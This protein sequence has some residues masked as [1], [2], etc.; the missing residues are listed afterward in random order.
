MIISRAPMRISFFGGG[1]DF[2]DYYLKHGGAVLSTSINKYVYISSNRFFG[3]HEIIVKYNKLE[4][5]SCPENIKHKIFKEV[6]TAYGIK[7]I[8]INSNAEIPAGTGLGSSSAFTVALLKNIEE[9]NVTRSEREKYDNRE[10]ADYACDIEINKLGEPIGKQDQYA[11]AVGGLNLISFLTTGEVIVKPILVDFYKLQKNLLMFYTGIQRKA[12]SVL[13]EQKKGIEEEEEEKVTT[14][15]EMVEMTYKA[16]SLLEIGKIDDFG[17]LLR[18]TWELKKQL[19]S[20]ISNGVIDQGVEDG[21]KSGAYGGKIIGAGNGGFI[22][23]YCPL[24]KQKK[25]RQAMQNLNLIELPFS[26]DDYGAEI[27]H[28]D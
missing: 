13:E 28:K 4:R 27:I 23:F 26:F 19:A 24:S 25:L 7:N 17:H 11:C 1:S 14:L 8:E 9:M 15:K 21:L 16:A 2:P 20:K 12:S 18:E 6:L 22:L 3:N 10:I 5:Q